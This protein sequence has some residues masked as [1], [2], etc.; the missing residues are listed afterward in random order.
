VL[1]EKS[2]RQFM[3]EL[4][5]NAPVPGG[6][7]V[8]ALCGAVSSAL[9][10]MVSALTVSNDKY[11]QVKGEM[12]G[13]LAASRKYIDFFSEQIDRDAE[14]FDSVMKA[15]KMPK[16]TEEEKAA[17]SRAI[18]DSLKKAADVP[19]KVAEKALE[20][21]EFARLAVEKGNKNAVTDG[22]VAAMMART[23]VLSALYNVEI[24]LASIKDETYKKGMYQRIR[25]LREKAETKEKQIL[26]AVVI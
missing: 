21:M 25:E 3:D 9:A 16:S 24:N 22:A 14:A 19:M 26:E 17:R 18:Q 11:L 15:Y 20:A 1:V 8:A 4:A 6:G 10:S 5:S 2:L 13:L 23:A 7:S 12:E